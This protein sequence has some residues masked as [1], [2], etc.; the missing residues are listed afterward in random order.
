M[1]ADVTIT[2]CFLSLNG[3]QFDYLFLLLSDNIHTECL[4]FALFG[5]HPNLVIVQVGVAVLYL[6]L[7]CTIHTSCYEEG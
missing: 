2:L 5:I 3:Q 4:Q 1:R 6:A 7:A